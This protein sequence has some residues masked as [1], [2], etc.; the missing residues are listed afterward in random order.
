M[1]CKDA[2]WDS[3]EMGKVRLNIL[4]EWGIWCEDKYLRWNTLSAIRMKDSH[5]TSSLTQV[6]T[7]QSIHGDHMPVSLSPWSPCFT[8][9]A[10]LPCA[11]EHKTL[12]TQD[13]FVRL[14]AISTAQPNTSVLPVAPP[15]HVTVIMYYRKLL[16]S[17]RTCICSV[18]S[19]PQYHF[20]CIHLSLN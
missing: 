13:N 11:A 8:Q 19:F 4:R 16:M 17:P 2:P 5:H 14:T 1:H 7:L 9:A 10:S 12:P 18:L 15:D 20:L 6:Q 3:M